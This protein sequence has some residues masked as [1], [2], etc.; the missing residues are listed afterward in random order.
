MTRPA[1]P[2][3]ALTLSVQV[4]AAEPERRGLAFQEAASTIE[5]LAREAGHHA[6]RA[7]QL[8]QERNALREQVR[9]LE[10]ERSERQKRE[11]QLYRKRPHAI[12]R[13]AMAGQ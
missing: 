5:R 10:A 3:Q 7:E 4:L 13:H 9:A 12:R 8:E 6:G 2:R 11:N 1:L